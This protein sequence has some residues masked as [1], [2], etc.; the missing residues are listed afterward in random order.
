MNHC[1]AH[2]TVTSWG[3]DSKGIRMANYCSIFVTKMQNGECNDKR[4]LFGM[5][6]E[7]PDVPAFKVHVF[8]NDFKFKIGVN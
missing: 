4:F 7:S 6:L 8:T 5:S 2:L 1:E 3:L